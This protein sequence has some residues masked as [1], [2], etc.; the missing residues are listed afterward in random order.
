MPEFIV[1]WEDE[2]ATEVAPVIVDASS[3]KEAVDKYLRQVYA[4]D[5]VFRDSVLSRHLNAC[6]AERFFLVTE[7]EH[8]DFDPETYKPDMK[9][10]E[11]RIRV[12]F[13]DTPLVGEKYFQYLESGDKDL[14]DEDAFE[15]IAASDH[16]GIAALEMASI[17]RI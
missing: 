7:Q 13:K 10:V 8:S 2:P 6:F 15:T 16:S 5:D 4:K 14:L 11:E 1:V 3:A 9:M 17:L 12:Y